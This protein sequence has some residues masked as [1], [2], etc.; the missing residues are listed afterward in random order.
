VMKS[1]RQN[2]CWQGRRPKDSTSEFEAEDADQRRFWPTI[3][4]QN[5]LTGH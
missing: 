1:A 4:R 3:S 5:R 2:R